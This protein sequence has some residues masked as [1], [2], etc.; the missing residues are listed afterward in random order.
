MTGVILCAV[1]FSPDSEAA[2]LWA[3]RQA[4]LTGARPVLLHVVHD[5]A[6]SPGFY[7][8]L[9]G[10]WLR[11]MVTVAEEMMADFL[12]KMRGEH[13]E[14]PAL[15]TIETRL[16]PGLP[17][18]RIV[19]TAAELGAELVVVGSRGRTGLSHIL[20][21]SVAERVVQTAPMPVTVVKADGTA[22]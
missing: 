9:E 11:P 7:R 4:E 13:P 3:C 17:P 16:V 10:D 22:T 12:A 20:L 8:T 5:P 15:A 18:G 14:T 6:S 21:G 19:E 2:L 1:D